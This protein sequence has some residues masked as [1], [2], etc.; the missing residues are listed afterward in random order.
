MQTKMFSPGKLLAVLIVLL[1][2]G[3]VL[4]A[5]N[6]LNTIPANRFDLKTGEI[7]TEPCNEGGEDLYSI[8]NGNYLVFKNYDFDSGV[9]AFKARVA[10]AAPGD[11]EVRL[12]SQSGPLMGT[13]H[14]M[15]TGGAQNWEDACCG[16]DNSQ[17]G[18][19][20]IYL[21]FHGD[22]NDTPA[23]LSSFVFLKSVV[24]DGTN[25]LV[26]SA[27]RVDNDDDETESVKSW[28]M[29]E[30]GFADNF[31]NGS[32]TNWL[33]SGML[34]AFDEDGENWVKSS[35][36]NL[37]YAFTPDVYINKTDTGGEWRDMAE[38]ALS[39]DIIV[40]SKDARPG[41]GF[42]SRD[43]KQ[44]VYAVLNLASN[45]I[46]AWRK[47]SDGSLAE[48]ARHPKITN[49]ADTK[50]TIQPGARYRLQVDWSPY[51][52]GLICFLRDARGND[53]TSFRTVIDLPAARRPLLVCAGGDARFGNVRFD[54]TVDL[55]DFK[56]QWKKYPILTPD[57]CNP[58]VWKWTDGK[59]YMMWRKFGK[60]TY[61]GI[62]SSTDGV[63]W[64]R[65]TDKVLKCTGDM[66]V[67]VN[68]FG[69]GRVYIT[70]GGANMPWW[71]SDGSHGF[72]QWTK[73][74]MTVG[75]IFGNSR[76]QE[77]IDTKQHPQLKPVRFNG[78]DYR[79]IAFTENW[80]DAPQPHT[81]VLL[82]N[83]LTN[84]V[85]ACPDPVIP[86]GTNFWG[87]KGNAVG[88][89]LVLPDGNILLADCSCTFDGYTGASEPSNVSVIVDGKQPWKVLKLGTLPNAPVSRESV[90]YQGPNFGTAFLYEPKNDTLFFYGGF[91]DYSIGM[92]RV[93][94]FSQSWMFVKE[95]Q[96]AQL[97][98]NN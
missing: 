38:A 96:K 33:S 51:S 4:A 77:F 48:I 83:T 39:A 40:D 29:P 30:I 85:L 37:C 74:Q 27:D 82:S 86:P 31:K 62:A 72:R 91:H 22:A 25:V 69:D 81:V 44:S 42:M 7:K 36:T 49:V 20:D 93:Q 19:R 16:V 17:A 41:I 87:E 46:E 1:A 90:W 98:S 59:Y 76:I 23:S 78:G 45:T 14:F 68:P 24:I 10:G 58:A 21:I 6:P 12:D 2:H 50:W 89:A 61:H 53:I 66:N 28:G 56:W 95:R 54:P 65:I 32:F 84:W 43:G 47:L 35:G 13:C 34:V 60:D 92:M 8:H 67:L 15:G 26:G 52:D 57:V 80:S 11:I 5:N 97:S 79:F 55:W 9:A 73:T 75:D 18:T 64:T 88:S 3:P 71:T 63:H 70:P 94:N